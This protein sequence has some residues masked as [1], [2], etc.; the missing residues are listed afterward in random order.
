M[1][2]IHRTCTR[3]IS[4]GLVASFILVALLSLSC[5]EEDGVE[6][7]QQANG[8]G[9]IRAEL[10]A[11]LDGMNFFFG[12][13]HSHTG[14]SEGEGTAEEAFQWARNE[15]RYDF[16][17]I[18]DHAE[19]LTA[20]EWQETAE[21]ADAFNEDGTF[22]ALRG[23]EWSNPFFGHANVFHTEDFTSAILSFFLRWFYDWVDDNEGLA[24]FNHPGR[25]KNLFGNMAYDEPLA[26]N[27]FA[28]ETGNKDDGNNDSTFLPYYPLFLDRGWRLAPT[29][30]QDN[31]SLE[32][33]PNRTAFIGG[34]LTRQSLLEAMRSRR[35]Y[36]SDDPN[37]RVVF[38]LG[39]AWMGSA[40]ETPERNVEFT[41][42]VEDDEPITYLELISNGGAV[43]NSKAFE[44]DERIVSWHPTVEV[45]G[46]AYYYLQ[47]TTANEWEEDGEDPVQMAVTAPIWITPSE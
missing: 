14:Y 27:F 17:A 18:T 44:D 15:A 38:K 30:N 2:S 11:A 37:V 45:L 32:T 20:E 28:V 25:E 35:L 34:Q 31:H 41:A 39:T 26:D 40:V 21:Q 33:G 36:S 5:S 23:F 43:V 10:E 29:N 1:K 47:V 7:N 12:N 13:L 8:E 16:Y 19:F 3:M 9:D 6:S 22:V 46:E 4:H 24:Q 42:I